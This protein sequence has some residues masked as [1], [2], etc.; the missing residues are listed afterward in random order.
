[1]PAAEVARRMRDADAVALASVV[2]RDGDRDGLPVV[3]V[4]A[5]ALGVPLIATP[6]SGIPELVD[7][8]TGWL[9]RTPDAAG[10]AAA[11]AEFA[12]ASQE[13]RLRRCRSAR[14]RVEREFD[15]GRQVAE[16]SI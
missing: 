10:I 7:S 2:A 8:T 16:L 13:E 15:L 4:E 9:A 11:I 1:M 6:V 14:G 12:S 5:A 3:L